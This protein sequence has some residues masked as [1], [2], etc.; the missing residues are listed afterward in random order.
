M[1]ETER[2]ILR[3]WR[4]GDAAPFHAMGNDPEVM[5]FL[6]PFLSR[7]EAEETLVR[8][9][10]ILAEFGF[11]FWAVERREDGAFIGFCGVKFGREDT[12]IEDEIEIGWR[13]ARRYW[14]Q[15]YAFEAAQATLDWVWANL[16]VDSV[17]AITATGNAKSAGLMERL[18]M[19]RALG[20]DFDHPIVPVGDPIRSHITYRIA[21]PDM[22]NAR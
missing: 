4:D 20:D 19:V 12:P 1:I 9:N 22:V 21:R 16:A 17:A 14:R 3:G 18:G 8:Q 15:G 7:T 2:L 10:A 6:G 13:L 11:C 5:E